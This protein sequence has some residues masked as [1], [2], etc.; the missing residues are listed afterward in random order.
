MD[1]NTIILLILALTVGIL[2]GGAIGAIVFFRR[3]REV[4]DIGEENIRSKL[5]LEEEAWQKDSARKEAGLE[6]ERTAFER[7]MRKEQ[8]ELERELKAER[9]EWKREYSSQ[10][11]SLQDRKKH[12]QGSEDEIAAREE[13]VKSQKEELSRQEEELATAHEKQKQE[14]ERI[15]QLTR[16]EARI[17]L[18]EDVERGARQDVARVVRDIESQTHQ[19]AD[20]RAREIIS[21]SLERVASDHVSEQVVSTVTLP[22]DEMKGRIIGRQGRNIRSIEQALGVDIV[23]DDTPESIVISCFDPVRR[24]I[25]RMAMSALVRD[26]R[27]HPTRIEKEVI[28]ATAAVDETIMDAGQQ[29]L[30]ETGIPGLHR[31]LQKLLGRLKFR[32]SYGQNQLYH[33]VE[34]AHLAAMIAEELHGDVQSARVGG[35][36]HDIGKA[37][38]HEVEGPHAIV[39]ASIARKYGIN[40]KIANC[41]EA[42]HHEVEM[43]SMEA[44]IVATADAVSGARPGARRISVE[45]YYQRIRELEDVAADYEEVSQAYALQAGREL[46]VLVKPHEIDDKGCVDLGEAIADQIHDTL[47]YPGQIKVTVIRESRSEAIAT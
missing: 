10:D 34:T 28:K 19:I 27:I 14:L 23:V 21:L 6:R 3:G 30:I 12:L 26:G 41:I 5:R 4:R 29:A 45:N 44:V 20:Q 46:R 39:G 36:L 47:Q 9:A 31:E 24:E 16:D 18:L 1:I 32:T 38:T 40:E 7:E 43:A 25:A 11:R 17:S 42:H 13:A 37:V 15:G 2:I 33:A 8:L 22:S 35:L